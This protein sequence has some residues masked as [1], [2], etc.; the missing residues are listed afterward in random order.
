MF[1]NSLSGAVALVSLLLSPALQT[2]AYWQSGSA[3]TAV[4]ETADRVTREASSL[5][6][7]AAE[8]ESTIDASVL[9]TKLGLWRE[10]LNLHGWNITI[11][12][13]RRAELKPRTL[14]QI[15]WDKSKKSAVIWVLDASDYDAP[16]AGILN[17]MEFTVV[18]ELVHLKF[19]SSRRSEASRRTEEQAVNHI[20][21]ALLKLDRR[22]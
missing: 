4:A 3:A 19:A 11:V 22:D 9:A 5:A 15:H 13:K 20:A 17:D 14:G 21:E 16:A 6:V 12:M 1:K 2:L 7:S 18:H 10:R 8:A